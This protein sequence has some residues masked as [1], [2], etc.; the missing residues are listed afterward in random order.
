MEVDRVDVIGVFFG[1]ISS[2]PHVANDV[3]GSDHASFFKIQGVR[4]VLAQMGIV[5]IAFAVKAA[6]TDAPAAVLIPAKRLHIARF[7]CD[8]GRTY[9]NIK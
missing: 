7:N 6:D 8:Y 9:R 1:A 5:I 4:E 2:V 3:S